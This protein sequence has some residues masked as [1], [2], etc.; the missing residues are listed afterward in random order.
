VSPPGTLV[1]FDAI[2]GAVLHSVPLGT[3]WNIYTTAWQDKSPTA[4][5]EPFGAGCS[6]TLG[7]PALA[8]QTGSRPALGSTFTAVASGLPFGLG[9]LQV[10]LSNTLFGGVVPLP[11][12]LAAIGMPGC[13]LLV[14]PL[15]SAV[16]F[17]AGTSAT[18]SLPIPSTQSLFGQQF[19]SQAFPFDPAANAFGFTASNGTTATLGF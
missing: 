18:W 10:G 16:L 11:F 7:V 17:D 15:V 3:M 2:T 14:D 19:F 13:D 8:A 12:S 1:I 4:T 5:Y 6:G 9:V